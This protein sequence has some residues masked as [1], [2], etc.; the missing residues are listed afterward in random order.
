MTDETGNT[1]LDDL[2]MRLTFIDDT[3]TALS[4]ADAEQSLRLRALEQ[5]VRDMRDELQAMRTA[6]G[7]DG[8]SEPPPPHY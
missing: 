2:E 1:R 4:T 3:V 8:H 5:A 7:H 6:L